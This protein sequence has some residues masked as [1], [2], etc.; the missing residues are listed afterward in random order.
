MSLLI[1]PLFDGSSLLNGDT[2]PD[3][4]NVDSSTSSSTVGQ[5]AVFNSTTGKLITNSIATVIG[6]LL[7]SPQV[8]ASSSL[9]APLINLIPSVGGVVLSTL[10][11]SDTQSRLSLHSAN[12]LIMGPGGASAQDVRLWRTA[13]NTLTLDNNSTGAA[14]LASNGGTLSGFANISRSGVMNI[15]NTGGDINMIPATVLNM[16]SKGISAVGNSIAASANLTIS[17]GGNNNLTLSPNGTGILRAEL[18][19][20]WGTFQIY[21]SATATSGFTFQV[22]NGISAGFHAFNANGFLDNSAVPQRYNTGKRLWRQVVDQRSSTDQFWIDTW[23]GST[24]TTF[25]TIN[26][27][28]STS[29]QFPLGVLSPT[30]ATSTGDLSLNPSGS[31]I[32]CNNKNLINVAFANS[33]YIPALA[34]TRS[35]SSSLGG[36]STAEFDFYPVGDFITG[37]LTLPANFFNVVGKSVELTG[38]LSLW[39]LASGN[40]SFKL[41]LNGT[42]YQNSLMSAISYWDV[43]VVMTCQSTG[44]SGVINVS[45]IPTLLQ[46]TASAL[47]PTLSSIVINTANTMTI[48][49]AGQFSANANNGAFMTSLQMY[50][51]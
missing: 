47:T 38:V 4:G 50:S 36:F 40:F 35:T 18:N 34:T 12:G 9:T 32:N 20:A 16:N 29:P 8:L 27:S 30:V 23:D 25:M 5:I 24:Y 14:T 46:G 31:N 17:T 11:G 33:S 7:T 51:R 13:A 1:P 22:P 48:R 28:V 42:I 39:A 15:F 37:S 10:V 41:Y 44:G 43:R 45:L 49:F 3:V 2:N 6:N 21:N 26:P 19:S